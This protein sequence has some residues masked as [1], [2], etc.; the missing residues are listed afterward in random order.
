MCSPLDWHAML[1]TLVTV[2]SDGCTQT[3]A[4]TTAV[5]RTGIAVTCIVPGI[6]VYL[7]VRHETRISL[8]KYNLGNYLKSTHQLKKFSLSY[9]SII[10]SV[11]TSKVAGHANFLIF[12]DKSYVTDVRLKTIIM[13][14]CVFRCTLFFHCCLE[15]SFIRVEPV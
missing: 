3:L 1:T 6:W 4:I 10:G 14:T 2:R 9:H 11:I 8:G 13:T 5:T 12:Y 7:R 15:R